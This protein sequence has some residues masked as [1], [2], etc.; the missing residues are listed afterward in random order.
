MYEIALTSYKCSSD[1]TVLVLDGT[2]HGVVVWQW[3]RRSTLRRYQT[4]SRQA[5]NETW[6]EGLIPYA[7]MTVYALASY[8]KLECSANKVPPPRTF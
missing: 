7:D 3:Q 1:S 4:C 8:A 2:A 5:T 6:K